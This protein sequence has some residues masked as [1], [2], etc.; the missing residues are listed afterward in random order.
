MVESHQ[1]SKPGRD[2]GKHP[3]ALRPTGVDARAEPAILGHGMDLAHC[4]AVAFAGSFCVL[5]AAEHP[6]PE[7]IPR[8][9]DEA[10]SSILEPILIEN[11]LPAL[12]AAVVTKRGIEA[13]G[14]VGVRKRGSDVPVTKQ[15][16]WHLG[17]ETKAM[18]AALIA[19]LVERGLL[20]WDSTVAQV[21]PEIAES[22]DPAFRGVT[23]RHLLSHRAGLEKD[24]EWISLVERGSASEQRLEAVRRALSKPPRSPPET[25]YFYSNLGYVVA[26][27]MVERV[28][29]KTW[30]EALREEIF[31]PLSMKTAGF[32]GI[33][34][35][36]KID[37]PWGHAS[38]GRPAPK[39]GPEADNPPVLGPAGTVHASLEDWARFVADLLRGISG[40]GGILQRESYREL[41]SP[42]F[43]G[44]YALGWVVAERDWAGGKALNHCGSNTFYYA[45]VW[46]APERGFAVL[47]C[48]NRG[49]DAH[50]ATDNAAG[51]LIRWWLDRAPQP[52]S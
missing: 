23:V 3:I 7:K 31:Q 39:N 41:L 21:F 12:A 29:G 9:G 24:L 10:V 11:D 17:S 2:H 46:V 26:G 13:I 44:E 32:G 35:P 33:G 28:T 51:K 42:P 27:A 16:L 47:V 52:R 6:A 1:A 5:S 22:F 38:G 48:T 8:D 45:N 25:S 14:A 15:D 40:E 34:T 30:E 37:Q 18:T 43:G 36:G 49:L 19:R 4:F 50:K 20:R